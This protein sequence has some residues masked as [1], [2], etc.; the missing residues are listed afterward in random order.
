MTPQSFKK[1]GLALLVLTAL[2]LPLI[3]RSPTYLHILI[4]LYLYAYMTT[5]WNLVG[6]F[7]GVLPLGHSVFVGI[8]AYTSTVLWLQ[9][10]ISPWIGML[11]GGCLAGFVAY[12]IGKPTLKMRGAYFALATMA[13]V[14]GVRVIVENVDQL[15]PFKLNGPRGLNIPPLPAGEGSLLAF[16][17]ATKEPY[18]YIILFMLMGVVYLTWRLSRS[19]LGYSLSAGGEEPEAA[20]ALGVNVAKCKVTAMVLS[21]FL[22]ALAGTFLAQMTLFIYPKSVLTLDLSFE[23]AFIAL[24]GGRGSLAGPIIGALML[25]PVTEFSRIYLSATLPGMHLILLG[26]ILIVVMLYQPRGL[27]EPLTRLF[28]RLQDRICST[29]TG[30]AK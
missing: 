28:N 10:G 16:Q 3:L 15:G 18:Y 20:E 22:T 26:V 5:T 27:S 14:E 1:T 21:A 7:A 23:L 30:G 11:V 8:G 29:K 2:A 4:M 19:K 6:G 24:I 17:F 25:R 13:F 12:L 9:W